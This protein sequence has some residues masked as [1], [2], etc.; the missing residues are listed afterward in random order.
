MPVLVLFVLF[1]GIDPCQFGLMP[2]IEMDMQQF[3]VW[4]SCLI[5]M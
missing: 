1:S 3:Q 4:N 2:A 5:C